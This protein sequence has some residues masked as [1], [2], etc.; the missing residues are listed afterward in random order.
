M[1]ED[2]PASQDESSTAPVSPGDRGR[3]SPA[4]S[5]VPAGR[6]SSGT[7]AFVKTLV[8]KGGGA[9]EFTSPRFKGSTRFNPVPVMPTDVDPRL[10]TSQE[11]MGERASFHISVYN[12][13]RTSPHR[14][15][16]SFKSTAQRF[17]NDKGSFLRLTSSPGFLA[18]GETPRPA[19][20][21]EHA[22]TRPA[23]TINGAEN[24]RTYAST[25]KTKYDWPKNIELPING[26]GIHDILDRKTS[27][28]KYGQFVVYEHSIARELEK[29]AKTYKS[30]FKQALKDH[31]IVK[32]SKLDFRSPEY[33]R[34]HPSTMERRSK[35][36]L[37]NYSDMT[38]RSSAERFK[39]TKYATD[40]IRDWYD[41]ANS[42]S[43]DL[44]V[45][46]ERSPI[47]YS[48]FHAT[49]THQ[50]NVGSEL[51]ASQ[52]QMVGKMHIIRDPSYDGLGSTKR[53]LCPT[54]NKASRFLPDGHAL[55]MIPPRVCNN[56]ITDST[57]NT[58]AREIQISPIRV[59]T[60]SSSTSRTTEVDL[61]YNPRPGSKLY[62]TRSKTEWYDGS[63]RALPD[64]RMPIADRVATTPQTYISSLQSQTVRSSMPVSMDPRQTAEHERRRQHI[65]EGRIQAIRKDGVPQMS[66]KM[67]KIL[68]VEPT[69]ELKKCEWNETESEILQR[70]SQELKNWLAGPSTPMRVR[71]VSS[72]LS[73]TETKSVA[74]KSSKS[75]VGKEKMSKSFVVEERSG[76]RK[77]DFSSRPLTAEAVNVT[78]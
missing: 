13:V 34:A 52:R 27:T 28:D 48:A 75:V 76:R 59:K 36:S 20:S 7:S 72:T 39:V 58:I 47:K 6:T 56:E 55:S 19:P 78:I 38:V 23:T 43:P 24:E 37:M 4:R 14:F 64:G 15:A 68:N 54:W 61:C 3:A 31:T 25:F 69:S 65:L 5:P 45:A 26:G 12:S 1:A 41:I 10:I 57:H 74:S 35:S 40:D 16:G 49:T 42:S 46:V 51:P 63:G 66:V 30:T 8:A 50:N 18:Y 60:M 29:T 17:G 9:R 44:S 70:Q 67:A 53:L 22:L 33:D 32:Q 73:G 2:E 21:I 62:V 77:P 11:D 71:S